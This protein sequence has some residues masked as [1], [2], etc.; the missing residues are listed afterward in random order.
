VCLNA[1]QCLLPLFF[2]VALESRPTE[3]QA[4]MPGEM[5]KEAGLAEG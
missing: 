5:G 4:G 1:Q 3:Q 2:D